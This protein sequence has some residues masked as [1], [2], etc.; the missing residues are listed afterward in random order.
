LH[1][2][3]RY[4]GGLRDA[5][6]DIA[7][8]TL[9]IGTGTFAPVKSANIENH[10]MHRE[11]FIVGNGAAEM[12]NNVK[13]ARNDNPDRTESADTRF[14]RPRRVVCVG[15]TS[16]RT[17]E[18]TALDDGTI[19]ACDGQT[20]IFIYPGYKFKCADALLTNFHLPGSTLLMLVCAFAGYE[21]TMEAYRIA[22]EN[23]YRFFSFG[24][25]MLIY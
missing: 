13:R 6:I 4:L 12:V 19:R 8:I 5:G 21:L 1:F 3:E 16:M 20:G 9:H 25:A 10:K 17:L 23:E 22:V 14:I 18:S 15:T 7:Y 24:D 11:Y 2:T